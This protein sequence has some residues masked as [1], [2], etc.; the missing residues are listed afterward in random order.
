MTVCDIC[1][2]HDECLGRDKC[3]AYARYKKDPAE[4]LIGYQEQEERREANDNNK[5]SQRR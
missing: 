1:T 2:Y 5:K 3:P 4:W